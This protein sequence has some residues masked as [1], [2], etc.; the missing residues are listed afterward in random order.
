MDEL[1]NIKDLRVKIT[2]GGSE[3][4]A[5]D[6]IDFRIPYGGTHALVGE[7]GCGKS[8]T[9]YSVMGLL[10]DVAS[11]DSGSIHF[12]GDDLTKLSGRELER[13]RG[14]SIGM[15]FQ[16]PLASLDPVFTIYSQISEAITLH[17]KAGGAQ[18]KER[19]TALLKKVHIP[20]AKQRLESYPHQLSGGMRQRVMIATAISLKPALLIADEPTTALDV[21]IQLQILKLLKELKDEM[22][23]GLF[24]ITH[25]LGVVS[26]TCEQVSVMYAG[27]IVESCA[28]KELFASPMHPYTKALLKSIPKGKGGGKKIAAIKGM[29]P[30][31]EHMPK[32]CRFAPRCELADKKCEEA[33]PVLAKVSTGHYVACIRPWQ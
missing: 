23:M 29:V 13:I 17:E 10:P 11:V 19:V 32:G 2:D 15:I 26:Y 21:T 22:G 18:L 28:T 3:F 12:R 24:L 8:I 30:S 6:G 14:K 1:L 31:P 4:Y 20:D 33:Q 16:E 27:R 9:A 7:S 5:V 25:D